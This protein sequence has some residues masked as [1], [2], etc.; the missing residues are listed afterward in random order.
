[1]H[2]LE[3]NIVS[4]IRSEVDGVMT[5]VETR[6][7]NVEFTEIENIVVPRVK[8]GMRS[9]NGSSGRTVDSNVLELDQRDFSGNIEG[10][11]MTASSRINSQKDSNRIDET[12]G[13]ITVEGG[14][15]LANERNIEWQTHAHHRTT[16]TS[17]P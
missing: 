15:L 11:Q 5:T 6:V 12:R 14:D 3:E 8:L 17:S 1:M 13:N 4:K 9:A 10:L 2:T 16:Y 7:Q